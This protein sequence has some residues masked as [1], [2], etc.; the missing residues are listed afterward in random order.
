VC[1]GQ[2][3]HVRN[4]VYDM[5]FELQKLGA[6]VPSPMPARTGVRKLGTDL[7]SIH[8]EWGSAFTLSMLWLSHRHQLAVCLKCQLQ[9]SGMWKTVSFDA[10]LAAAAQV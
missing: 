9:G 6:A 7:E 1:G 5:G 3:W 10:V 2:Q 4:E 8:I